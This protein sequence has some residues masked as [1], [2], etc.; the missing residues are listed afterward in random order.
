[1][2]IFR[3]R[4]VDELR[5]H[6]RVRPKW[7]ASDRI[8]MRLFL[9]LEKPSSPSSIPR[10]GERFDSLV[11]GLI[12]SES[13]LN[14]ENPDPVQ[15]CSISESDL[16]VIKDRVARSLE[17]ELSRWIKDGLVTESWDTVAKEKRLHFSGVLDHY[18]T[19][20]E[21]SVDVDPTDPRPDLPGH[22]SSQGSVDAVS[23]RPVD[24]QP[25][26]IIAKTNNNSASLNQQQPVKIEPN[27][28]GLVNASNPT[29]GPQ[30][31][32]VVNLNPQR[33]RL[34]GDP[35]TARSRSLEM[36]KPRSGHRNGPE[37]EYGQ[38]KE[39]PRAN[40]GR[41][42]Y[43]REGGGGYFAQLRDIVSFFLLLSLSL[44]HPLTDVC[45][46]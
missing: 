34:D 4:W 22:I 6:S 1:M 44:F 10:H 25:P 9:A 33:R 13:V 43:S 21:P 41:P 30:A 2:P 5:Y 27:P 29:Q 18:R 40:V 45:P 31:Q 42:R 16:S 15:W 20:V 7:D 11:R 23:P 28:Q 24:L 12:E 3:G 17:Y 37:H 46:C 36:T 39:R 26:T 14:P 38:G 8:P 32:H 19:D 35:V